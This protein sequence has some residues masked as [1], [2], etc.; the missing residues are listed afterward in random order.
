MAQLWTMT[1]G[2]WVE[3]MADT[4]TATERSALMTKVRGSGNDSTELQLIRIFRAHGITSW[5]RKATVF[6]K[7]DFVFPK[8]KLA[9]FG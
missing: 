5:R 6:G 3:S 8:Q 4:L 9:V 7:P 1:E 2:A